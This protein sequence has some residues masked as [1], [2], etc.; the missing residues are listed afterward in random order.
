MREGMMWLDNDEKITLVNRIVSACNEYFYKERFG[1]NEYF[2][3]LVAINI[4]T[5]PENESYNTKRKLAKY[6]SELE[7]ST[8]VKIQIDKS[9]LKNHFFVGVTDDAKIKSIQENRNN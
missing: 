2:P 9:I 4:Q 6:I 1:N 5:I 8:K 7:K 3:D